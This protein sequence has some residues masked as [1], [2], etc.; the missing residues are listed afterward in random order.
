[1]MGARMEIR[2]QIALCISRQT[3]CEREGLEAW[4]GA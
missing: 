3:R 4:L 1:M 2:N